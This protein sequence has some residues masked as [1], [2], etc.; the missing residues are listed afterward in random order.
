MGQNMSGQ[1]SAEEGMQ[2]RDEAGRVVDQNDLVERIKEIGLESIEVP[3]FHIESWPDVIGL[4]KISL[5][6]RKC[7]IVRESD[8][9]ELF[10]LVQKK[11]TLTCFISSSGSVAFDAHTED[12]YRFFASEGW[13]FYGYYTAGNSSLNRAGALLLFH[14]FKEEICTKALQLVLDGAEGHQRVEDMAK[15]ALKPFLPTLM[16]DRIG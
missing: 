7:L 12:P 14:Q 11:H 15:E 5:G 2:L 8:K 16:L 3:N 4:L 13:K 9:T 6:K 1:E 10:K